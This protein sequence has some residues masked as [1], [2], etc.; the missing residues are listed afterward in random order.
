MHSKNNCPQNP[1]IPHACRDLAANG[2]TAGQGGD[3][4]GGTPTG[5]FAQETAVPCILKLSWGCL[6]KHEQRKTYV[7]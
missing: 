4:Q 6:W 2:G 1:D 7:N 5:R 3:G